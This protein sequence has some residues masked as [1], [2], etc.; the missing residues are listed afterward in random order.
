MGGG[1]ERDLTHI[2]CEPEYYQLGKG[3][4]SQKIR[5]VL[6]RLKA[7]GKKERLCKNPQI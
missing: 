1:G 5:P 7:R 6:V 4:H 2:F 3:Q